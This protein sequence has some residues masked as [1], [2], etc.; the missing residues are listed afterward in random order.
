VRI[1]LDPIVGSEQAGER[2]ALVLSP[3]IINERAPII[4]IAPLTT[5]NTHRAYPFEVVIHPP[6]GGLMQSSKV[7]LMHMRSVDKQRIT[8]SYG[9]ASDETMRRVEDAILIAT[10]IANV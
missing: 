6:E 4:L 2:P 5:R 9:A 1:R 3:D 7:M 8:G 10:G